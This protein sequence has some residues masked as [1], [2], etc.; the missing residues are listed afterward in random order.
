MTIIPFEITDGTYTLKD[1]IVLPDNH[2]FT[3][4]QIEAIKQARFEQ[5]L[6]IVTAPQEEIENGD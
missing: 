3:D 6:A 5:Y 4:E 1:A 2:T